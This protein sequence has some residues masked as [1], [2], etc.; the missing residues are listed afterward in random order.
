MKAMIL[1]G[2]KGTRISEESA[3]KPKP[4]I[5]IGGMPIIWHIM[6]IYEAH[7]IT[8]FIICLG[9]KGY[10][11]KDFFANYLLHRSNVTIKLRD[12]KRK[13]HRR[14]AE[15]WSV[16]LVETGEETQVGGRIKKAARY[17]MKDDTFCLTYGDGVAD[18]DI[19][20][21][22]AFHKKHG[23]LATVAAVQPPGRF[24]ALQMQGDKVTHFLEKPQGDGGYING[25]FFVLSRKVV[26][27]IAGNK[28]VW[29]Q[30]PL[31]NI[32]KD[33]QLAAYHHKG[34]WQPM[35]TLRDKNLLEQLWN[36]GEAPWKVW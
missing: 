24:G 26:D 16:T 19:T 10:M 8:E 15:D 34:F 36:S 23:L 31:E 30:E 17:L 18:I 6:K 2:G 29:E 11:I 14:Q 3:S 33:G 28:T 27:Y 21:E 5:E 35:D 4:M 32:A 12:G 9:Y 25:G 22:L 13:Y 20:K 1:A 7:G